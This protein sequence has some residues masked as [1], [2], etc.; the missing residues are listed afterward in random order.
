[1]VIA[2]VEG[3]SPSWELLELERRPWQEPGHCF[4][5]C[6]VQ[7]ERNLRNKYIGILQHNSLGL[8]TTKVRPALALSL[9]VLAGGP[10]AC[11]DRDSSLSLQYHVDR[12]LMLL[13]DIF[14]R[15]LAVPFTR[16]RHDK[17]IKR[18]VRHLWAWRTA[19][20][21][22]LPNLWIHGAQQCQAYPGYPL[23]LL[24]QAGPGGRKTRLQWA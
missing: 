23:L 2:S 18:T 7:E 22:N 20:L 3:C 9:L 11:S 12:D 8:M 13:D 16:W 15:K 21:T 19:Q 10:Q 4:P 6:I 14:P 17:K 24:H 5:C 1:M